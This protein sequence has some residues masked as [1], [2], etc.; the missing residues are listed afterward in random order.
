MKQGIKLTP[1]RRDELDEYHPLYAL[2]LKIED[3][4]HTNMDRIYQFFE[5]MIL[6]PGFYACVIRDEFGWWI[7]FYKPVFI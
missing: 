1:V 4:D 7:N 6:P 5:D 3:L 2:N